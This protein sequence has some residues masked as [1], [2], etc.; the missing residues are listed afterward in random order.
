VGSQVR[1]FDPVT[2]QVVRTFTP[3]PGFGGK[4]VTATADLNGDGIPD[5]V[6]GA[7]AGGGPHVKV[8]D[9]VS[10]AE[11]A[12][13]YAFAASF[14]GG[15]NVAAGDVNGDGRADLVVA[16]GPGGGPHVK[17]FD[18]LSGAEIASFYA[19]NAAFSGGVSVAVG[20]LD[21]D[22]RAEIVTGAGAGG[23]PHVKAFDG[24]TLT[25]VRSFYAYSPLFTGGVSVAVGDLDGDGRAEI[26]TGAG[27][28][29]SPHVMAFNG[30]T[31]TEVQSFFAYDPAFTG[32]VDVA[33][34]DVNRDGFADIVTGAGPGGGP[35]VKA[36]DGRT[37][38]V[39]DSFFAD[40]S[41]FLGGVY[42]A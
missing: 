41:S 12:S 39:L 37:L 2:G 8:F 13:F 14:T 20:D 21:G 9:G 17:V 18:G 38:D 28:G 10:G 19:Y 26:V 24:I 5:L 29:G 34:R 15:V 33:V 1:E 7:G 6:F 35:H 31:L 4:V 32:G 16:A 27:A 36:F 11:I 25:E 3:F 22:G 23:G 42:V 30:Q 40:D